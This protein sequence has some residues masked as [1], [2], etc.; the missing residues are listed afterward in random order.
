MAVSAAAQSSALDQLL[1]TA[2]RELLEAVD[3]GILGW[4][5]LSQDPPGGVVWPGV[6][7]SPDRTVY[8]AAVRQAAHEEPASAG[9]LTRPNCPC[10]S[11]FAVEDPLPRCSVIDHCPQP[12]LSGR[13]AASHACVPLVVHEQ[14]IGV[15]NLAKRDSASFSSI[16]LLLLQTVAGQLSIALENARLIGETQTR[17]NETQTLLEVSDS[18]N[19]TLDLQEAVRRIARAVAH[20]VGADTAGAYLLD[21]DGGCLIPFAGYRLPKDLLEA[22]IRTP[23]PVA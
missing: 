18:V 12:T 22:F 23:L 4:I 17:L 14:H 20:V 9:S 21:A 1:D 19:S 7:V 11:S 10:L 5:Y 3:E 13:A 16:E 15:L 6:R 2:L 8:L